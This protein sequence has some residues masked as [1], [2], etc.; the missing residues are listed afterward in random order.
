[1][2]ATASLDLRLSR[3]DLSAVLEPFVERSYDGD[4]RGWAEVIDSRRRRLRARPGPTDEIPFPEPGDDAVVDGQALEWF[5]S[6][7]AIEPGDAPFEWGPDRFFA[8]GI[9]TSRIHLLVL[10]RLIERLQPASVLEVGSGSGI[11]LFTLAARFPA[12]TFTGID[13]NGMSVRRAKAMQQLD[14]VPP[15]IEQFSPEPIVDPLAH[16]R[17]VLHHGDA[18]ALPFADGQ[19]ELVF[20]RLALERMQAFRDTVLGELGRVAS[21]HVAMLEAFR[22]WNADGLR[23]DYMTAQRY[24]DCAAAELPALGLDPI[25]VFDDLPYKITHRPVLVVARPVRPASPGAVER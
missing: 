16:R 14:R 10:S 8:K 24:L 2:A 25:L 15:L 19:F 5:A 17:V 21:T 12:V 20:T 9:A 4:E 18:R 11:N 6:K 1:M 23:R 7:F 3:A 22:E 13:V